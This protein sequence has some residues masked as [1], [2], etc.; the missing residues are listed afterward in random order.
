MKVLDYE[1]LI[2]DLIPPMG[3][4]YHYYAVIQFLVVETPNG[5]K[6]INPNLGETHGRTKEEAR[7]KMQVRFNNWEEEHAQ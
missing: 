3:N 6:Q 4:I 2:Q 5:N 1:I 7:E